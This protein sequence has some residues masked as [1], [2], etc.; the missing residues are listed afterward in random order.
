MKIA[1]A[2]YPNRSFRSNTG[3]Y[4][5]ANGNSIGTYTKMFRADLNWEKFTDFIVKYF[6]NKSKVQFLQFASSD[7]S[8]AYTQIIS[9]LERFR[10]IR[11]FF[12]IKAYDINE[13]I[14]K[15]AKSGIIN[16]SK[17]DIKKFTERNININ[18]YFQPAGKTIFIQNDTLQNAAPYKAAPGLTNNVIFNCR[19]MKDVLSGHKDNSNTII[20]CRN[21]LCYLSDTEI[22][23][24][25]TLAAYKLNKGSLFVIG[26][27]DTGRVE[28]YLNSNGFKKIM[29]NVYQY[30]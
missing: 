18:K 30:T 12:P 5:L 16:I 21:M 29:P 6:G 7:G 22:D 13:S 24:Y 23:N 1:P 25:I 14:Y 8:E 26:E 10:N 2:A 27:T 28:K 20:M 4:K 17:T 9:L 11:K 3:F 19:D 15:T